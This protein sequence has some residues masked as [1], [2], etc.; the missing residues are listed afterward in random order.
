MLR[1]TAHAPLVHFPVHLTLRLTD[2]NAIFRYTCSLSPGNLNRGTTKDGA[3][4]TGREGRTEHSRRRAR[5]MG[6]PDTRSHSRPVAIA[7]PPLVARLRGTARLGPRHARGWQAAVR[8]V[9]AARSVVLCG[10][11]RMP[12]AHT[13][14]VSADIAHNFDAKRF[15]K[16]K[17]QLQLGPRLV[18]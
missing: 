3:N 8:G 16:V 18:A 4:E 11:C 6:R 10:L 13:G 14:V 2:K 5:G 7:S 9:E 17:L 12:L 1:V 15:D